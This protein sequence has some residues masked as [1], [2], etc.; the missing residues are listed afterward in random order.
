MT[1]GA[2]AI[3]ANLRAIALQDRKRAAAVI[4][5]RLIADRPHEMYCPECVGWQDGCSRCKNKRVLDCPL[6]QV[7]ALTLALI[8]ERD[9]MM[10]I[11]LLIQQMEKEKENRRLR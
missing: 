4:L 2:T 3:S 10:E 1:G 6:R 7:A 5:R 11:G 9:P 8:T